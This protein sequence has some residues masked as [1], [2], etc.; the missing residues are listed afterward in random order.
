MALDEKILEK[1]EALQEKYD[2]SGQDMLSYL[3]GL[4]YA[5]YLTYWDYIN[6]DLLLQLQQPRTP[7]PDE[8]IFII[9]HQITE[10]YFKLCLLEIEQLNPDV[11]TDE[12]LGKRVA[13][14]NAYFENMVRSFAIMV[15]GMDPKQFLQFRMALLPASGFQSAQYRKIE[16]CSTS[17]YHLMEQSYR[18]NETSQEPLTEQFQLIYWRKGATELKS[19]KKTLTLTQFE[20][21]YDKELLE[22]A[23]RMKFRNLNFLLEKLAGQVSTQTAAILRK[24]D[25]QVNI[26]WPLVHYKSAVRYLQ[27]SPADI[28]ATGGTNWQKYLPPR[29]QK[30]IFFPSLWTESEKEQWGKVWVDEQLEQL[31]RTK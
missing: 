20:Q 17:L 7:I 8:N 11:I 31:L 6:L 3:E 12:E 23:E 16:I 19:G 9:Y 13:R 27:K 25:E 18:N 24:F 2:A 21:K 15:D 26:H 10:L 30:R 22:L 29:F 1:I 14:M 4:L 28:A 5:D